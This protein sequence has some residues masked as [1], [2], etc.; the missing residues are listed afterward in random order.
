MDGVA[1]VRERNERSMFSS[2]SDQARDPTAVAA[3][4][5]IRALRDSL[6]MRRRVLG[7]AQIVPLTR[8]SDLDRATAQ[9]ARDLNTLSDT[10]ARARSGLVQELVEVFHV[11]EVGGRPPRGGKARTKGQWTIGDLK[12]PVL[13]DIRR[14]R[15]RAVCSTRLG[16][17]VR[18][19]FSA[20]HQRCDHTHGP[21]PWP[22]HLLPWHQ[23]AIRDNVER[24]E[25]RRR[26]A[27]DRCYERS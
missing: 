5:R 18:R 24:Q 15:F 22:P 17:L 20:V 2:P 11:V 16:L 26:A 1:Q 27:M 14:T 8:D 13:G 3:K 4:E 19:I 25:T 12:L 6:H 10:L 9:A 7:Q 23:V 21:L